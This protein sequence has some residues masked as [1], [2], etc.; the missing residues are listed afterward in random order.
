MESQA[1]R[2]TNTDATLVEAARQIAPAIRDHSEEAERER[3]LSK[4]VVDALAEAGLFRMFTPRSLGGL[5]VDPVTCARVIEE[6][7][8]ADSAAGWSVFVPLG[9]AFLCA[10]LP[11]EGA[12]EL[13]GT[14]PNAFIAGPFHPP[15]QATPVD[16]GYR[17]NGRSP[18]ASNCRDATW[19]GATAMVMDGSKPRIT[20][21]GTPD[22]VVVL[23]RRADCEILDTWYVM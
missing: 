10:R 15:M 2:R 16:G 22:V 23:I 14:D 21:S 18:F 12:E 17:V 5:E 13:F 20:E 11:D 6:V 7:A 8:A 4:P 3:H 9:W 1:A 19:I